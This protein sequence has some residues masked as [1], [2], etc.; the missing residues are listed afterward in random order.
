MMN[1]VNEYLFD[2]IKNATQGL[3]V[4]YLFPNFFSWGFLSMSD[5]EE[6]LHK[7]TSLNDYKDQTRIFLEDKSLITYRDLLWEN[8]CLEG[9]GLEV[10]LNRI[11]G[12]ESYCII[13]NAIESIDDKLFRK[14][15]PF[16]DRLIHYYGYPIRGF[17][18]TLIM[19][20]YG[21]TPFG[22]HQDSDYDFTFQFFLGPNPKT[23]FYWPE[24]AYLKINA[25]PNIDSEI[26]LES[27]LKTASSFEL[28]P[29]SLFFFPNREDFH[30]AY[31][32]QFTAS[33]NIEVKR[34]CRG[35][36]NGGSEELSRDILAFI[37]AA[38]EK[39]PL[40]VRYTMPV[41]EQ[42]D[43]MPSFTFIDKLPKSLQNVGF[44]EYVDAKLCEL[45]KRRYS[46]RGFA[47][48]PKR[49]LLLL[50]EE[51][52]SVSFKRLEDFPIYIDTDEANNDISVLFARGHSMHFKNHSI[53]PI[54]IEE[55]NSL[56]PFTLANLIQRFSHVEAEELGLKLLSFLY[57]TQ[58]VELA[59]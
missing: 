26:L 34:F 29:N 9:E 42:F 6:L 40:N 3:H 39:E 52:K 55:I 16:I 4:P 56:E 33:V 37:K 57:E 28:E 11:F 36:N 15:I 8:P 14:F 21:Y 5:V 35:M 38:F 20:N 48:T 44:G 12:E 1:L 45:E 10:W 54:I 18:L 50:K 17:E 53:L 22:I 24:D 58:A 46:N 49:R 30:I 47:P 25:P 27:V 51:L 41:S 23:F 13:C 32:P 31:A 7:V 2:K 19:G 43:E 59:V